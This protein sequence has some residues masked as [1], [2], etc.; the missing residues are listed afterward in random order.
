[1]GEKGL[2][3]KENSKKRLPELSILNVLFCFG[4]IFIHASSEPVTVWQTSSLKGFIVTLIWRSMTFV[5]PA[6]LFMSGLKLFKNLKNPVGYKRYHLTR[7]KKIFLPYLNHLKSTP[8]HLKKKK[9]KKQ[10]IG[11]KF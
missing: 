5:V 3:S 2:M 8:I 10:V 9:K 6:F 11:M 7:L 4:V 1:M